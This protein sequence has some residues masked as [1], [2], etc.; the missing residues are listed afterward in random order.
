MGGDA[1]WSPK[2]AA[3]HINY[4]QLLAAFLAIKAFGKTWQ[5]TAVLLRLDNVTAVS[6]INQKGGTVSKALCQLAITIWNWCTERNITLQ[7]EHLPGQLNF[8]ADQESRMMKDRYDWKLK[9]SVF[10]QIQAAID[11][12]KW[13]YL[14]H[15]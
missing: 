3:Q 8:Q 4:L 2:E 13:I 6:Y 11:H 1:E 14:H 7:A 9:Q 15:A 5:N 10:L 12:W